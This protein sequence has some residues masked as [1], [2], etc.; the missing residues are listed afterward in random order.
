MDVY[1]QGIDAT[2]IAGADEWTKE[3]EFD[4]APTPIQVDADG[5]P[6]TDDEAETE[7]EV[8]R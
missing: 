3:A 1:I 5:N 7:K 8:A 4:V 2:L 6:I